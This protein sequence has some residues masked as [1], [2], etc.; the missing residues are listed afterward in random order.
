[1]ETFKVVLLMELNV[2][3]IEKIMLTLVVKMCTCNLNFQ[4]RHVKGK[5]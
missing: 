3:Q 1:M 2:R 5:P 4:L